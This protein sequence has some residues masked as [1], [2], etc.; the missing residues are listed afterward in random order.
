[1]RLYGTF[2]LG[3]LWTCAWAAAADKEYCALTVLI[4]DPKGNPADAPIWL[5][6]RSGKTIAASEAVRGVTRICD[7]PMKP[8]LVVVGQG[9]G[10]VTVWLSRPLYF[11]SEL[12]LKLTYWNCSGFY[13]PATGCIILLRAHDSSGNPIKNVRFEDEKEQWVDVSDSHGRIHYG[14]GFGKALRAVLS[15]PNFATTKIEVPCDRET[16]YIEKTVVLEPHLLQPH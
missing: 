4:E 1:M 9:C 12:T 10:E 16:P 3:M 11:P 2:L 7:V 5:A 14:V 6:E 8:F 15:H 13:P